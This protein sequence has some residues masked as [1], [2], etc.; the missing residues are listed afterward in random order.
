MLFDFNDYIN[1]GFAGCEP[2]SL[3]PINDL[4]WEDAYATYRQTR[5]AHLKAVNEYFLASWAMRVSEYPYT[6]GLEYPTCY[7][8]EDNDAISDQ[9]Y[10]EYQDYV[11]EHWKLGQILFNSLLAPTSIEKETGVV[12]YTFARLIP[13]GGF[14]SVPYTID[15][16][17][18][19]TISKQLYLD[20]RESLENMMQSL[21]AI[22]KINDN[23]T[24]PT[25]VIPS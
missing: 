1:G 15:Y 6:M 24:F 16:A 5:D 9:Y 23:N 4:L 18:Y 12:S 2:A 10:V 19:Q 17:L 25:F 20:Y 13:G 21:K 7:S 3:T 22:M 8:T 14:I 11:F